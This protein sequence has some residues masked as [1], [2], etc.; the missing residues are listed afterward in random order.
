MAEAETK[1]VLRIGITGHRGN[2]LDRGEPARLRREL[3]GILARLQQGLV[4]LPRSP[5]LQAVSSLAE[6]AD[7][8][9]A[10]AAL[11]AGIE[12]VAPVPFA[13]D[14][15]A[16]DFA[17]ESRAA[18]HA[19]LDR[20]AEVIELP[21]NYDSEAARRAAYEAVGAEMVERSDIVLAIWDGEQASGRGG[22]ADVVALARRRQ[23]PVLWLPTGSK[24]PAERA[25]R[26]LLADRVVE[27]DG[28]EEMVL[29]ARQILEQRVRRS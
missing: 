23:R 15:Y 3:D 4:R 21:G 12:L 19:L 26:L 10:D 6:G 1:P 7:R 27:R 11:A 18:Y 24:S 20:A 29:I 8:L 14:V 5:R 22:T 16:R 13:R 28:I 25:P 9:F 17:G 2:K